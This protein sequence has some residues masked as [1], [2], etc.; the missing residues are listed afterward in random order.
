MENIVS[1][2]NTIVLVLACG[3]SQIKQKDQIKSMGSILDEEYSFWIVATYL[4]LGDNRS[5]RQP[6]G[7]FMN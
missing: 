6:E 2:E 5:N 7:F 3:S 4:P 1:E